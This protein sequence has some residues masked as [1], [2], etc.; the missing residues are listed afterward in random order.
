MK[1]IIFTEQLGNHPTLNNTAVTKIISFKD[2]VQEMDRYYII[3]QRYYLLDM[4]DDDKIAD[5]CSMNLGKII[6]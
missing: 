3:R 1:K 2:A 5:F 4:S 6:D